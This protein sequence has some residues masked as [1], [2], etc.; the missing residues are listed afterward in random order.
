MATQG[1]AWVR[2][3]MWTSGCGHGKAQTSKCP[4]HLPLCA[5]VAMA[6]GLPGRHVSLQVQACVCVHNIPDCDEAC[7]CKHT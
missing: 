5:C 3:H 4:G 7:V 1:Q 6:A 2:S